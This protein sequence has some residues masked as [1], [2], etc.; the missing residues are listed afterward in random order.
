MKRRRLLSSLLLALLLIPYAANA[1]TFTFGTALQLTSN[2]PQSTAVAT[3]DSTHT[4]VVYGDSS[5]GKGYARIATISGNSISVGSAY[6][7]SSSYSAMTNVSM[8]DSTHAV[9]VYN[10]Y[11]NSRT[12]KVLIATISGDTLS[13]GSAVS[14][15]S[16][17]NNGIGY[18]YGIATLD[19]THF[20]LVYETFIQGDFFLDTPD[21]Y[22]G[23]VIAGSVSGTSITMGSAT[24]FTTSNPGA[25]SAV[26]LDDTHFVFASSGLNQVRA[27]TV[28]GTSI[29]LG[30]GVSINSGSPFLGKIDSTHF[31]LNT[32]TNPQRARI[33]TIAGTSITLGT[34]VSYASTATS[35]GA[36]AVLDSTHGVVFYKDNAVSVTMSGTT[37][38]AGTD[39]SYASSSGLRFATVLSTA[40]FI[41]GY[42]GSDNKGYLIVGTDSTAP[43]SVSG[44]AAS[45][46][47]T[48]VSLSWTNPTDDDFAS[49]TI[50]RSTTSYPTSVTDGTSVASG[51]TGTS[52]T[53]SSLANGTYYYSIFSI[54]TAGNVSTAANVSATVSVSSPSSEEAPHQSAGGSR[55]NST[56]LIVQAMEKRIQA[57]QSHP[58]APDQQ[59]TMPKDTTDHELQKRTCERA[60]KW[61][62][63]DAKML[64]RV[65]ARLEKRFGFTCR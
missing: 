1:R 53:D 5:A 34:A 20:V 7:Y 58:S 61:F 39:T 44:L 37:V 15:S 29:T 12:T 24:T 13:F 35:Y 6:E 26:A 50:R 56:A 62:K 40:T 60:M 48:D 36:T 54:D 3:I 11:N 47:S 9:I 8:L 2:N 49:N 25:L 38:T 18:G 45:V 42:M 43:S 30:T 63:G 64:G 33:G 22:A 65:N 32:V 52:R 55:G 59:P 27:G 57:M 41:V 28:S 46:S 14:V 10:D 4:L 23:Y 31:L 51:L 19:S 17:S 16:N 21:E